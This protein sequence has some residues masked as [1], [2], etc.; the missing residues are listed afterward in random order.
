M[1]GG[2]VKEMF[3]KLFIVKCFF[4]HYLPYITKDLHFLYFGLFE[5]YIL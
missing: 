3:L 2:H 1:A 5:L 4:F